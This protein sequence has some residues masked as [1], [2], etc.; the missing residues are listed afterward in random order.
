[1]IHRKGTFF[2]GIFIFLI[3]FLGLPTFWK[4]MFVCFCGLMLVALSIKIVIPN[5]AA[6]KPA[7][8][9][10]RTKKISPVILDSVVSPNLQESK[11]F[12]VG[13]SFKKPEDS[14]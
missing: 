3:P 2:L 5:K 6:S 10:T 12:R 13:E 4:T 9:R 7:V 1:M 11:A 14:E 8:K